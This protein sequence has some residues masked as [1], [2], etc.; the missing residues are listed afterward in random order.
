MHCRIT[1]ERL[2]CKLEAMSHKAKPAVMQ[3]QAKHIEVWVDVLT[4]RTNQERLSVRLMAAVIARPASPA[5]TGTT[6]DTRTAV[7]NTTMLL[8]KSIRMASHLFMICSATSHSA[9]TVTVSKQWLS[10]QF[11]EKDSTL[12][13]GP[14]G[15]TALTKCILGCQQLQ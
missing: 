5:F 2:P 1:M 3:C 14:G 11:D 10:L 6:T 12:Y 9:G 7:P 8:M 13:N 15:T 4:M